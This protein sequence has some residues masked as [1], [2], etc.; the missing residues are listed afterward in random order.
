MHICIIV[1]REVK[2]CDVARLSVTVNSTVALF[3]T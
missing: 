2:D 1:A 3:Q